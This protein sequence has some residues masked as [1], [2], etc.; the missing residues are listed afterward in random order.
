MHPSLEGSHDS[1]GWDT[2]FTFR[3][4]GH[5]YGNTSPPSTGEPGVVCRFEVSA[6]RF[7]FCPDNPLQTMKHLPKFR[8]ITWKGTISKG[9]E[10]SNQNFSG[11]VL[12]FR[13]V[14]SF[15]EV[16]LT[17]RFCI[18]VVMHLW[19]VVKDA[20]RDEQTTW[21]IVNLYDSM[22]IVT[23]RLENHLFKSWITCICT[24]AVSLWNDQSFQ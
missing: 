24:N 3:M 17:V 8:N 5:F 16:V 13:E 4:W 19:N 23:F 21:W 6:L 10:S 1:S 22:S 2:S 18:F 14:F 20:F 15:K 9:K 7:L 11:D 12:V